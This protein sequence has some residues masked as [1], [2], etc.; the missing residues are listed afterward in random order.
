MIPSIGQLT[1]YFIG[2]HEKILFQDHFRNGFQVL[3]LHDRPGRVVG[4]RQD[5]HL[6]FIRN[7]VA[8]LLRRQTEL[9][10]RLQIDEYRN[11][12]RQD[13]TGFIGNVAWL[14][15]QHLISRIDHRAQSD[16]NGL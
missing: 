10:F 5:E 4:E 16:V 11:R 12:I 2:N 9:I 6:G 7:G 3:P 13:G 8:E 14:G 15:N 1:V